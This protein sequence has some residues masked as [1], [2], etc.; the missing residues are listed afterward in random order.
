M[1]KLITI[2]LVILLTSCGGSISNEQAAQIIGNPIK[3][4]NLNLLVTQN[5]FPKKM[6]W[7]DAKKA[8]ESLGDGWRLPT[9]DELTILYQNEH[10]RYKE[11]Y[12][13]GGFA[14]LG[15]WSSSEREDSLAWAKDFRQGNKGYMNKGS[16]LLVR[17]IRADYKKFIGEPIRVGN[18]NFLVAQND[19]PIKMNWEDAKKACKALGDGWRLP[20]RSELNYIYQNKVAIGGF[21]NFKYWSSTE[22]EIKYA[23]AGTNYAWVQ[24]LDDGYQ[25]YDD[26]DNTNYVRAIRAF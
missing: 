19:F 11:Q 17:A 10:D 7:E 24:T 13:I 23:W 15:Y 14:S 8:C 6:N 12:K 16:G 18:L 26:K 25:V 3:V 1:K 22:D 4:G 21:T 2:L 9:K 5:Y 20:D